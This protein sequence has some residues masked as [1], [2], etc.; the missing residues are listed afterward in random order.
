MNN[1]GALLKR[2]QRLLDCGDQMLGP[3]CALVV[4]DNWHKTQL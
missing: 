1:S 3:G 2:R 4:Q